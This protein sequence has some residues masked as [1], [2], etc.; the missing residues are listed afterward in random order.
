MAVWL[1]RS[2]VQ[3]CTRAG[4]L[5]T[6]ATPLQDDRHRGLAAQAVAR[7]RRM[8]LASFA[9]TM[10]AHGP[11]PEPVDWRRSRALVRSFIEAGATHVI[12]NLRLPYAASIA[13]GRVRE[14]VEP[15]SS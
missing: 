10:L 13:R 15:L 14:I 11:R 5:L 6:H 8:H 4:P 3:A 2:I 12:L 9:D 7:S 1:K